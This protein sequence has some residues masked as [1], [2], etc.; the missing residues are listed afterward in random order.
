LVVAWAM[1]IVASV[2]AFLAWF[3]IVFTGK[4]TEGLQDAIKLGVSYASR[5]LGVMLML[6]Q[7]YPPI[8]AEAGE[9]G[10]APPP[11]PST[12]SAPPPPPPP[13]TATTPDI[14]I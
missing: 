13:P 11:A 5:A 4:Q 12:D 8:S 6:T 10:A 7:H 9:S 3:V 1:N 14:G 2:C